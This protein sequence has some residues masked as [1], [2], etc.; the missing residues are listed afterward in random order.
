MDLCS[1]R[2]ECLSVTGD[3]FAAG[4]ATHCELEARDCDDLVVTLLLLLF[5]CSPLL[6]EVFPSSSF[7]YHRSGTRASIWFHRALFTAVF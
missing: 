5:C 2:K 4:G 6:S 7:V 1:A 3:K